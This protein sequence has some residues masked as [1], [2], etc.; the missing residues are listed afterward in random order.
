M[1]YE[2]LEIPD[3][4]PAH[5]PAPVDS[6]G[7][8]IAAARQVF[9]H[10]GLLLILPPWENMGQG[11]AF[12]IKLDNLP[13]VTGSIEE[14]TEVDQ[15]VKRHIPGDRLVD[16][17]FNLNY[18][19]RI[20]GEPD[21]RPSAVTKIHV[22]IDFA[23]PGGPDLDGTTPGHSEL[24]L[25]TPFLPPDAVDQDAARQGVPVTIEPYPIMAEGDRIRLSWGGEI[26]WATVEPQ[27]L[28]PQNVPLV[29]TVD[30][31]TILKAGDTDTNGL[32]VVFE[33]YDVVDNKSADWSAE[34]RVIVDTGN[35]RLLAPL[36]KESFNLVLD[37]DQ[38][39][40]A[41]LTFQV[42]TLGNDFAVGDEI[43][44]SLSGLTASGERIE[45]VY[46]PEVITNASGITEFKRPSAEVRQLAGGL[47]AAF[48]YRL[49]KADGS[50]DLTS[51]VFSPRIVGRANPLAAPIPLD[52]I[53]GTLDPQLPGTTIEIPLD[54]AMEEGNA[55]ALIWNGITESGSSYTPDLPLHPLSKNE[56][57]G[58]VPIEIV[59]AGEHL[60]A[61]EGGTLDLYYKLLRDAVSRE[62]IEEES[63][64]ADLLTIGVPQAEL[65]APVV[66]GESDGVLDPADKPNGTRL[67]VRQYSGQKAGDRVHIL[68]WGSNTGRYRDSLPVT[69]VTE[70]QDIP[71][72]ISAALIEGN[73]NGTVRA[74]YWV[75]RVAGGTSPSETLLMSI[76]AGMDL[77]A[78]SV[79]Q[80]T[81]SSPT[82][83][84]NPV[85]AKDALTVVIPDYGV[86]PGDQVSV[87]WAGTAGA[88][89]HTTPVQTLPPNRE[90]AILVSVIAFNLGRSVTVTYT[91]TRNGNESDP[92]AALNL[93]V[94]TIAENDLLVTKPR[95][96]EAANNGEG[97]EL[98]VSNMVRDATVRID[99]W[100][101]IAHNQRIWLRLEG[102]KANGSFYEK[103]W[104]G[105][106]NWVSTEWY[107]QGYG[108]KVVP[109]NEL[110]ELRD[111][112]T[113][114]IEFKASFN[115]SH[116]EAEAVTFP[117]RTYIVKAVALMTPTLDSVKDTGGLEVLEGRATSSLTLKLSGQAS[118]GQK[119][120]IY[121]GSG[122]SAVLK[123]EA[124]ADADTGI[125]TRDITVTVGARRLYA[126][127]LYSVNPVYSNVRTLKVV[128]WHQC[129]HFDNGDKDGWTAGSFEG[130][131]H[132]RL[133][134]IM[135][136]GGNYYGRIYSPYL[137]I[138]KLLP[139]IDLLRNR[140]YEV[141]LRARSSISGAKL[142]S[143]V[144]S[145]ESW[146]ST[147]VAEKVFIIESTDWR[148]YSY[149]FTTTKIWNVRL[150]L[151]IPKPVEIAPHTIDFDN[152]CITLLEE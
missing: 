110:R 122:S 144:N 126:K 23:P 72:T 85:A 16:G 28:P 148:D 80:A 112:S 82:Q 143:S 66:E 96:L 3:G 43:E 77:T 32:A 68:W 139:T 92:S 109:Y 69:E 63:L 128:L 102:I 6:V 104:S 95:I 134:D 36:I 47:H 15:P 50:G 116:D 74:M 29:I 49:I 79:K 42:F 130:E 147:V 1:N 89:S 65:P 73:R 131:P 149:S 35:S 132:R 108:E 52:E 70:N 107:L 30:E 103:V 117:P 26:I 14:E 106:S 145:N 81:G 44:M 13:M 120:E 55:I 5:P 8:N 101:L 39:G 22:K 59:V 111:G 121:E 150:L 105:T 48:F 124:T 151:S 18:D 60:T 140:T 46:P 136:E 135:S 87:T 34:V 31:A 93:T 37:M 115:Q 90:I 75:K 27:H 98:D 100:P 86:Q 62:V 76:G 41:D 142:G 40:E 114:R 61:I 38:L 78:P 113:L 146:L 141:S 125:W 21:Y 94:Q 17:D 4:S 88:G 152:I 9:P 137:Y 51:K 25:T 45:K 83:Q 57:E 97:L 84:L 129:T 53:A 127:A 123:G 58:S 67:I 10:D 99:S 119:V 133:F 24:K 56:A 20:L 11:D 2:A 33:V 12:R 64:H 91:V 118:K 19:V 54:P 7:I 71:F 138:I